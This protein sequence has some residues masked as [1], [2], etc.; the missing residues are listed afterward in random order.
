MLPLILFSLDEIKQKKQRIFLFAI[1]TTVLI[2]LMLTGAR[3]PLIGSVI[4]ILSYGYLARK[5]LSKAVLIF[6]ISSFAIVF[7]LLGSIAYTTGSP[8]DTS[9]LSFDENSSLESFSSGRWS[10]WVFLTEEMISDNTWI[11]F[12]SG[13]GRLAEW[14]PSDGG[15]YRPAVTNGLLSAWVP[16]GIVGVFGYLY[17]NVY[18]WRRIT[19][20]E[21]SAYRCMAISMF[22][23]YIVTDQFETHWQGTN[24]LWYV[25]FILYLLTLARPP[26][27]SATVL[28]RYKLASP[29]RAL[30]HQ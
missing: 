23:A 19:G 1:L 18:L 6:T 9:R 27:V 14:I 2:G 4:V 11:V 29:A 5:R 16:F 13:L 25:S 7:L 17:F 30:A 3:G 22:L 21:Q 12:G 28:K 20:M 10:N 15:Y 24:M 26:L 8:D